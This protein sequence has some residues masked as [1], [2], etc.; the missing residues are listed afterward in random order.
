MKVLQ[1]Y[2]KLQNPQTF[3]ATK[4][5]WYA[6]ALTTCI[7][8]YHFESVCYFLRWKYSKIA[9]I[10]QSGKLKGA[11]GIIVRITHIFSVTCTNFERSE[12]PPTL[13]TVDGLYVAKMTIILWLYLVAGADPGSI[14][15][16]V[17]GS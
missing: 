8:S 1:Q 14:K 10:Q 16:R 7:Y 11:C 9:T 5:S 6:V 17:L 3:P 4:V 2:E 15:G 12:F 13:R